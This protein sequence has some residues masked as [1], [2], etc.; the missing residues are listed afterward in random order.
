MQP[1]SGI[2]FQYA[3]KDDHVTMMETRLERKNG[4][5][6]DLRYELQKTM[7]REEKLEFRLAEVT[8]VIP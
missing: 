1:Y 5:V 7:R 6:E 3:K 4:E 8:I 2:C